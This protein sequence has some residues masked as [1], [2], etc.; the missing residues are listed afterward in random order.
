MDRLENRLS[1]FDP[2]MVSSTIAHSPQLPQSG[3]QSAWILDIESPFYMT[4]DST[5]FGSMSLLPSPVSIKTSDGTPLHVVSHDIL[6]TP[7]FMC[8]LFLMCLSFTCSSFQSA[9]LLIMVVVLFLI[10]MLVLPMIVTPG[11]QLV[12]VADF[13]IHLI[14]RSLTGFI[15]L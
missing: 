5:H 9:R 8:H 10:L 6:H 3:T 1:F 15:F 13:M 12:L 14:S 4:H 11:P 7:N 2:S